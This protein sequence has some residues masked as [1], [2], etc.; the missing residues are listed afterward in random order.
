MPGEAPP[1]TPTPGEGLSFIHSSLDDAGLEPAEFRVYCHINRRA[2]RTG[3]CNESLS[4][5]ARHCGY[6]DGIARA[7]LKRLTALNMLRRN[8]VTGMGTEYRLNPPNQ[9]KCNELAP[10]QENQRGSKKIEGTPANKSNH[11]PSEK[12]AGKGIPV[13]GNPMKG[14]KPSPVRKRE[15]WQLLKDEK[16]LKERLEAEREN[17]KPDK[18]MIESL[19]GQLR[20]VKNEIRNLSPATNGTTN[21][22]KPLPGETAFVTALENGASQ[23]ILDKLSEPHHNIGNS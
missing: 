21:K 9:W 15:M 5:I 8:Y 18:A 12:V 23:N 19:R 10:L 20:E 4:N 7:A 11:H 14:K 2:G 16:T 17:V 22:G 1:H 6:C 13:E 3:V